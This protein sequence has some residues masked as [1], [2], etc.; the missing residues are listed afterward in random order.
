M[1]LTDRL[2][3]IK[4][5]WLTLK[6]QDPQFLVPG[7]MF[8][9]YY[10]DAENTPRED[11]NYY[12]AN[13]GFTLPEEYREYLLQVTNGG[14]GPF[15]VMY[16][17]HDALYPLN[18]G[19][20]GDANYY[21]WLE[22]NLDHYSSEF[23]VTEEK[24]IEYLTYKIKHATVETPP[25]EINYYD[26]GYLFLCTTESG[27]HY[28]MPVNGACVNEVWL[29][30]E[31]KRINGEGIEELYFNLWPEVRFVDDQIKTLSF[32]EW[33]EDA[34]QNWFNKNT[35]LEHRLAA[36]KT[37]WYNLAAHDRG[38]GVFG[39]FMHHY[40]MNETLT[41]E[42]LSSFEKQ[43]RFEMPEEYKAYL[44]LVSNGGVGPFYGMY[45]LEN[46]VI[47]LN[48]DSNDGGSFINYLQ[49]N[50]D[51]FSKQFPVTD[52]Q[53]NDYLLKKIS[54][55]SATLDPIKLDINAGGYV[56]ISEYGCG[57]Y[58]IM[59][60]NGNGAGEIWY[61]QKMNA[62]KLT[63]ELTDADGTVTMS[64]SY[65]DDGDENYFEL[66]PELKWNDKQ[67]STINFLEW[68]EY[69]QSQWFAEQ[70]NE[71]ENEEHNNDSATILN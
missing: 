53:V 59:P 8:H 23:P 67:A 58:Y 26:A 52:E 55:P 25:I 9:K 51:H 35:S 68:L 41:D 14:V 20:K 65:G 46:S 19:S 62:N 24:I 69:K 17:L 12:E 18:K 60:V 16:P 45:T 61:L 7:A 1:T 3:N 71:A 43:Y 33:I 63:Y 37:T 64:G 34:Q 40:Q 36:V 39:A 13:N 42:K 15:N 44:K 50:P 38:E 31:A 22:E 56:F 11:I 21:D 2:K 30:K 5:T 48:S 47:A 6:E 29:M 57:G 32:L 28:I 4:N 10:L 49:K 66:H 54:N 27:V 70:N